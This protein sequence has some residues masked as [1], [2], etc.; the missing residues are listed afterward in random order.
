MKLHRYLTHFAIASATM[1]VAAGP[2]EAATPKF[3]VGDRFP[4][5]TLPS[6]EDGEPVSLGVFRGRKLVLHVWA[7]W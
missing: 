7:S 5:L 6:L 1:M 3:R 2:V 4:D